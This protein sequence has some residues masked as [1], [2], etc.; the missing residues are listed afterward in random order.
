LH[1]RC[2]RFLFH[3]LRVVNLARRVI[4]DDDQIV[5][6]VV[7]K[8]AVFAAVDVQ[9]HSWQRTSRTSPPV[10]AAFTSPRDQPR[11]L[12][13]LLHPAVAQFNPVL[14]TQLLVEVQHVEIE[15]LLLIQRKH[16]LRRL[17]RNSMHAALSPP[18]IEQ[19]VVSELL[20]SL[21]HPAHRPVGD[22]DDL[23][24]RHP[25]DL[26]R[27]RF[28]DHFLHFHHPLHFRGR[29]SFWECQLPESP[30]LPQPDNSRA[31]RTGQ[32]TC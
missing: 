10:F 8:P 25:G 21:F 7:L 1:H 17:H 13:R 15:V 22:A 5:I 3:H 19:P 20:V 14:L 32:L 18:L 31:N 4:H 12:Q 6:A 23:R 29:D 24:R 27:Y 28:Q 2:R 9:H 16:P 11:S 30:P 26:L